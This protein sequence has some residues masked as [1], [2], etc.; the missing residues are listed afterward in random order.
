LAVEVKFIVDSN[1]GK[2]ARWLRMMGYDA[3]FYQ[4]ID[5]DK[6]V[7]IALSQDR[8]VLTRDTQIMKRKVVVNGRVKAVLITDD[9]P[10]V[11]LRYLV[12][13]LGLN[14]EMKPFSLC[15]ECNANLLKR[16][17]DE[18]RDR[19]PPYVSKTQD[20]YMECPM[21]HRIYWQGTHW[22]AMCRE[23]ERLTSEV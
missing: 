17:K 14:Y 5:D 1:V 13:Q 11:Q 18:V 4:D 23:L 9:N 7:K 19:V 21:C 20:V 15:L 2:L 6:M 12:K 16:A 10:R 22:E 8:V 3:L